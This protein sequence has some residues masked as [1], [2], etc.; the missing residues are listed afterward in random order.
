MISPP[1]SSTHQLNNQRSDTDVP[2]HGFH[3][4]LQSKSRMFELHVRTTCEI[5]QLRELRFVAR[6]VGER[7]GRSIITFD[8][9]IGS[10]AVK[11]P[12]SFDVAATALPIEHLTAQVR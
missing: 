8:S 2:D 3:H 1:T 4:S 6:R 12:F 11:Q 9:E 7:I 5:S 10:Q